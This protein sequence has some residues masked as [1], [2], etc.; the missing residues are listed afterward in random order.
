MMRAVVVLT[1]VALS[2]CGCGKRDVATPLVQWGVVDESLP[3]EQR[4]RQ[5]ALQRLFKA[6]QSGTSLRHVKNYEPDLD[7]Q[8]AERVFFQEGIALRS[9]DWSGQPEQDRLRVHLEFLL[10][11]PPGDKTVA[12]DRAYRVNRQG[13][14]FVIQRAQ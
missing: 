8:E 10:D 14:R 3:A 7:F 11:E 6:I 5:V 13:S 9:W 2:A 1:I 12:Y 4:A